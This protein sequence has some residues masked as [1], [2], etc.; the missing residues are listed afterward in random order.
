PL[1]NTDSIL[2]R[3]QFNISAS[4][5]AG[6][7]IPITLTSFLCNEGAPRVLKTNGLIQVRTSVD[8]PEDG[9]PATLALA[10]PRPNPSAGPMTMRFAI[11]A[12][13]AEGARVRLVMIGIDGRRVRMLVDGAFPPGFHEA[14]WDGRDDA[15][16]RVAG[17]VYL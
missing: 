12:A 8:V 14:A 11:P 17:G 1:A 16:H 15:G 4:A 13:G 9:V 7:N 6:T 10:P 3:V 5:P 2:H